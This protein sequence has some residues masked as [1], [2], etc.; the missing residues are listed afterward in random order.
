MLVGKAFWHG[1]YWL[2]ALQDAIELVRRCP[3]CQFHAK[4]THTPAQLVQL[5]PLSWPF[6]VWGIDILGPFPKAV[7]GYE[8]LYVA[9]DKFT[10]WPEAMQTIKIDK[11]SALRF[12]R[13]IVSR[14]GVPNRIITD[15]GTQFTSLLFGAYCE[16]M[17]I[18]I[19]YASSH[20][21]QSNGQAE[22]ANAEILKGLKTRSYETLKQHGKK[23]TEHLEP[24]LWAN[25]TTPSRATEETPFFLVYGAEAV[26]PPEITNRSPRVTA[27]SEEEQGGQRQ[28]DLELLEEKRLQAAAHAAKYQQAVRRYHQRYVRPRTLEVGDLVLRRIL[29]RVGMNK[30]SP[31]WE[32]PF[33]V[34]EVCRPGCVRLATEEGEELPHPWNIEHLRKFYP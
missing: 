10:K 3:A 5:I 28:I 6:A 11:H 16:D 25:R 2:T 32:G 34:I 26:L 23:W 1:F 13:G 24:V 8:Y 29:N 9:I 27:Y 30:L 31:T 19:C 17:G 33:R 12:I 21:P 14:F 22:R 4:Q 15:N 18:K 7:G 20:H